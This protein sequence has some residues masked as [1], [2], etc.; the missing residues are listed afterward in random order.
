[1]ATVD[2]AHACW[3]KSSR[4][5]SQPNCVEVAFLPREWRKSSRSSS[6][7]NCVEVAFA[8]EA[9]AT[10]DSKDPDGGALVFPAAHWTTFLSGVRA[11]RFEV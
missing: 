10:R 9:V 1:M 8:G 4:S 6:E 5:S 7:A 2:L 11:G 3:R